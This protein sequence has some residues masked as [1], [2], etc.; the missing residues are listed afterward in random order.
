MMCEK[1]ITYFFLNGRLNRIKSKEKYPVEMFYG[2]EYLNSRFLN[3]SIIEAKTTTVRTFIQNNIE[4]RIGHILRIPILFSHFTSFINF[5]KLRKSDILI[6]SNHRTL[7]STYPM[8]FINKL[9]GKSH[10]SIVFFMGLLKDFPKKK[11]LY[12]FKIFFIAKILKFTDKVYFLNK[13]ELQFAVEHFPLFKEIFEYYPFS[14][15]LDFW[16]KEN[17]LKTNDVL[18]IGNDGE[19][20]YEMVINLINKLDN[21]SF[22]VISK[23]IDRNKITNDR[24]KII[25]GSWDDSLLSDTDILKFYN[26]SKVTILPLKESLQPSGQSV[27]LQSMACGTPVIITKTQGFWDFENFIDNK[28]ICF[29]RDNSLEE[30]EKKINYF[31][32]S[33]SDE[34]STF[35][36]Y[37]EKIVKEKYSMDNINKRLEN[38]I[39]NL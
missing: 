14:V 23:F 20:D 38:F 34:Y 25:E 32:K 29:T 12:N 4:H 17:T 13:S 27:A 22:T 10:T 21:I 15:D 2:Y 9:F 36:S 11:N 28:N 26:I 5:F 16:K 3:V 8:L 7:I 19:R 18:F 37:C 31:L 33:S 6:F 24:C 35:S 30:W 39:K 1:K